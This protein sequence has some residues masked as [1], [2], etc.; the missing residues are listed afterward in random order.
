MLLPFQVS[1]LYGLAVTY[2]VTGSQNMQA[3][4]SLTSGAAGSQAPPLY[5][6]ILLVSLINMLLSQVRHMRHT[7][8]LMHDPALVWGQLCLP[9]FEV[10][11]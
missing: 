7:Y 3:L 4:H 6:F 2:I 1:F 10:P 5:L 8:P 11:P 9:C